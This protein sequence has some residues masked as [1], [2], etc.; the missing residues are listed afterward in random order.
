M[1]EATFVMVFITKEVLIAKSIKTNFE[2][3]ERRQ[4]K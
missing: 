3:K 4:E 1:S 2:A